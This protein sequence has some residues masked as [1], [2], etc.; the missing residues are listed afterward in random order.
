MTI[1]GVGKKVETV[2]CD[3]FVIVKQI[4]GKFLCC[5]RVDFTEKF[6]LNRGFNKKTD[7]LESIF[8]I[9]AA[10]NVFCIG[11]VIIHDKYTTTAITFINR[12]T[13]DSIVSTSSGHTVAMTFD[14]VIEFFTVDQQTRCIGKK[15]LWLT[16]RIDVTGKGNVFMDQC[17]VIINFHCICL[18]VCTVAG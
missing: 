4:P 7:F 12:V 18:L 2:F 8:H 11:T 15:F 6:I 10:D 3:F 17:S 5:I 16:A 13:I 9:I 1:K 14:E